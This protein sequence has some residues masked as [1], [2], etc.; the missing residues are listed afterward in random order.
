VRLGILPGFG[1]TW[2]LPRRLGITAA[3]P[4]LLSGK[5]VRPRAALRLGLVDRLVPAELLERVAVRAAAEGATARRRR[6]LPQRATDWLL[7]ETPFGRAFLRARVGR[8]IRG[9]TGGHYPAPPAILA[10]AL[11]GY[12][13]KRKRANASEAE[14][15]GR[16]A[17]TPVAKNLLC[18]FRGNEALARW[19]WTGAPAPVDRETRRAAVV[20]AGTMGGAIAGAF[21]ERG[22]DVRL[23]DVSL[24]AVR[25]GLAHAAA[26]LNRRVAR[27]ALSARERDAILARISPTTDDTGLAHADLVVEA[28]PE[29][30]ELKQKVFRDAERR[31]SPEAIW[32][33]T[34]RRSRSPGSRGTSRTRTG[35]SVCTSSIRFTGCRL[36]VSGKRRDPTSWRGPSAS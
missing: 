33:R 1:G 31:V 27:R 10:Q 3:L 13:A 24:E 12:G 25:L 29:L 28:V 17:V 7:G 2:R 15:F 22:V 32:P 11:S 4:L 19:P 35:S 30:L 8:D 20:G 23:R 6:A 18:L 21:A 34:R 5:S 16:L 9:E 26:P 14:A 36:E